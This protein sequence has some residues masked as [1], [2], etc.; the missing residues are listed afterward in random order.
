M[1]A[2]YIRIV[3]VR[4]SNPLSS[5]I[6]PRR[7]KSF[8]GFSH[9]EQKSISDLKNIK[10]S[11]RTCLTILQNALFKKMFKIIARKKYRIAML[12]R[13]IVVTLQKEAKALDR[14]CF[15]K[16]VE[17]CTGLMYRVAYTILQND[18]DCQDAVQDALLKAWSKLNSLRE[19]LGLDVSDYAL[20]LVPDSHQDVLPVP[21]NPADGGAWSLPI[22][23][24]L[25]GEV[26][27][28]VTFIVHRPT[29]GF[30]VVC[31]KRKATVHIDNYKGPR[32]FDQ[33]RLFCS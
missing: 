30:V 10:K 9:E 2:R 8:R 27:C 22:R 5:T 31:V 7:L 12:R 23:Q 11:N 1:V 13:L 18:D 21:R 4:G 24:A 6:H 25:T 29:K 26:T 16:E 28:E 3:E 32:R 15:A 14:E 19:E 20:R 17:A 33:W